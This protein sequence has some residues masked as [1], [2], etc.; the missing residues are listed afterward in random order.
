MVYSDFPMPD[1]YPTFPTRDQ[2]GQ[3]LVEY[4]QH[5]DLYPHMRLR[6][7]VLKV[8]RSPEGKYCVRYERLKETN[9]EESHP[10][11]F[12]IGWANAIGWNSPHETEPDSASVSEEMFDLVVVANGHNYRPKL[13][14]FPGMDTC[15]I[16][17]THSHWYK[18]PK[19][20]EG[21]TVLVVGLGA[22]GLE[23]AADLSRVAKHVIC[24]T[25]SPFVV[26]P[27]FVGRTPIDQVSR[28]RAIRRLPP[29]LQKWWSNKR[30]DAN[31]SVGGNANVGLPSQTV[32]RP[33]ATGGGISTSFLEALRE[34][35]LSVISG[36]IS[37]LEADS[38]VLSDEKEVSPDAIIY[39]TGYELDFPFLDASCGVRV[40]ESARVE[41]LYEHL[42]HIPSCTEKSTG[43]LIPSLCFVGLTSFI[44]P[45]PLSEL[46]ARW[47]AALVTGRVKL[48]SSEEMQAH[49]T[50]D[51]DSRIKRGLPLRFAHRTDSVAYCDN[52]A[53]Q[54]EAFPNMI[55]MRWPL[56]LMWCLLMGPAVPYEYRLEGHGRWD[57]AAEAIMKA[58]VR[59]V[60]D[61]K[62]Y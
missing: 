38:V 29:S 6:H 51:L 49:V 61:W 46:Q 8:K 56:Y 35:R 1:S 45:F 37:R 27:H 5:F 47:I 55:K 58:N 16:P 9:S 44:I 7:R 62:Q 34:K 2:V 17:Q 15:C 50:L 42:V 12:P 54:I 41:D 19:G 57:G 31:A 3:Y 21:K 48:P 18:N 60:P 59:G 13:P 36:T 53:R 28:N 10:T 23:V 39:C 11:K 40:T 43:S 52:I 4:A 22:S 26:R 20:L 30:L 32:L 14:N 24:I 25:R 33:D